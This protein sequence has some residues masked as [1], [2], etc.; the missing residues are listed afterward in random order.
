LE[1][2]FYFGTLGFLTMFSPQVF[3]L[4]FKKDQFVKKIIMVLGKT[5]IGSSKV[6][7]KNP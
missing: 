4:N 7:F 5:C 2:D 6:A 1:K 3:D